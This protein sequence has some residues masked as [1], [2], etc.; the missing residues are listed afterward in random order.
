MTM[1]V[2]GPLIPKKL[3]NP[4]MKKNKLSN[5]AIRIC[6]CQNI[7]VVFESIC[8]ECNYF[9]QP[10]ILFQIKELKMH[11]LVMNFN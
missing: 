6:L 8:L 4:G 1:L 3:E 2:T 9:L 5:M 11:C 10:M 7:W